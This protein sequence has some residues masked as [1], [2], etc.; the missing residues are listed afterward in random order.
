[1]LFE[2]LSII[3]NFPGMALSEHACIMYPAREAYTHVPEQTL[4]INNTL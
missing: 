3:H 2:E 1:M 4:A